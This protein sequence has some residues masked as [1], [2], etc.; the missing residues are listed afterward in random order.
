MEVTIIDNKIKIAIIEDNKELCELLSTYFEKN[1]LFHVVGIAHDGEK[2]LEL[3]FNNAVDVALLDVILPV[4]DGMYVLENIRSKK[5]ENPPLVIM[6]TTFNDEEFIE[7]ALSLGISYLILKPFN[8]ELLSKRILEIYEN[9]LKEQDHIS[10]DCIHTN[11]TEEENIDM[12]SRDVLKM[13]GIM[14]DLKGYEYL[15]TAIL[16][17]V[18]DHSS[19]NSVTKV[20]YPIIAE[21]HNTT[22][23]C[24][25]KSM[26]IA[27]QKAWKKGNNDLFYGRLG[28]SLDDNLKLTNRYFI[29][30]VVQLYSTF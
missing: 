2:G 11:L 12:F 22:V 26:R 1:P 18:K 6:I 20:L 15:K 14:P 9:K 21:T 16:I 17:T 29:K 19:I 3:I 27:L 10:T 13:A 7:Y 28:Y 24:V 4:K 8:I 23:F 25:E 5:I 30:A